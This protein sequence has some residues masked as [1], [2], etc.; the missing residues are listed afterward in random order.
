MQITI[1]LINS[2]LHT[3]SILF[4]QSMVLLALM[5][6][7]TIQHSFA[8]EQIHD[9]KLVEK[10]GRIQMKL[11]IFDGKKIVIPDDFSN[12]ALQ[13]YEEL[14]EIEK[15]VK[16]V[17]QHQIANAYVDL[18]NFAVMAED[19]STAEL[20]VR[21]AIEA[22]ETTGNENILGYKIAYSNLGQ[23]LYEKGQFDAALDVLMNSKRLG[24]DLLKR[25]QYSGAA[26]DTVLIGELYEARGDDESA[27]KAYHEAL[28]IIATLGNP[29]FNTKSGV[30]P[31][32]HI[33]PPLVKLAKYYNQQGE[34]DYSI[35]LLKIAINYIQKD[36]GFLSKVFKSASIDIAHEK[37]HYKQLIEMLINKGRITEAMEILRMLK[38]AE[39]YNYLKQ[40]KAIK[41]DPRQE[42]AT[43]NAIEAEA[44]DIF[45]TLFK[46]P[47]EDRKTKGTKYIMSEYDKKMSDE[48]FQRL[49]DI[50]LLFS[51]NKKK[52]STLSEGD[53]TQDIKYEYVKGVES[54]SG[55]QA[56][57][58]SYVVLDEKIILVLHTPDNIFVKTVVINNDY[59]ISIINEFSNNIRKMYSDIKE[60]SQTLYRYLIDPVSTIL[61][62][63]GVQA[64]ILDLDDNLRA[65]PF[66]A[67][68]DGKEWLIQEYAISRLSNT[69]LKTFVKNDVR[70]WKV[71]GMGVSREYKGYDSLAFVPEE[72]D[73][74]IK[75]DLNDDNGYFDG[76]IL[77]N[78]EFTV[79]S[80]KNAAASNYKIIH[81]ATHFEINPYS[82]SSSRLLIGDGS[83]LS[84]EDFRKGEF[85][86]SNI[87]L[88]TLSACKT[89]ERGIITTSHSVE[90]EG[91]G[92]T[93]HKNGAKSVL[94]TLWSVYDK[95]TTLFMREFYSLYSKNNIEKSFAIR[96]TQLK[97]ITNDINENIDNISA[98]NLNE[99][100]NSEAMSLSKKE[101]SDK[102]KMSFSHPYY[103]A[104]FILMGEWQ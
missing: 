100:R 84:L 71:A 27:N 21:K 8:E 74:I 64:L 77:L 17:Y 81:F 98:V 51:R 94:A 22:Y 55:I 103:W 92:L 35:F 86:F 59:L 93:L 18:S 60:V 95:S 5:G 45:K 40:D 28:R 97:F 73:N 26:F 31:T 58:L 12:R 16:K 87:N 88:I 11:V 69:T 80:I 14:K 70:G 50:Q 75:T 90:V 104:P 53:P 4:I 2:N 34:I 44:N 32:N 78:D 76:D 6:L 41:Y 13:A 68:Y 49:E 67:L 62:E 43:F 72:L 19:L 47:V 46:K 52:I 10:L 37:S 33:W 36:R 83:T 57:I 3:K 48:F 66:S 1:M 29:G 91:L 24:V 25:G 101:K 96:K 42:R 102:L 54:K 79:E 9:Y 56:A 23:I 85:D 99:V 61:K 63:Q 39:Y 89:G 7:F 20:F 38:E 65:I 15:T 82:E 30:S